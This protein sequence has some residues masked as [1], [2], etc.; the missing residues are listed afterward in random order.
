VRRVSPSLVGFLVA[1]AACVMSVPM[2][3]AQMRLC[4][5]NKLFGSDIQTARHRSINAAAGH[6]I[7]WKTFNACT[8][9]GNAFTWVEIRPE[10]QPDGSMLH[11]NVHCERA[12]I[13]WQCEMYS[14]RTLTHTVT[15]GGVEHKVNVNLPAGFDA[16]AARNLIE[17]AIE[18]APALEPAQECSW[19][20][21]EVQSRLED[22]LK[23]LKTSFEFTQDDAW[24]F[25][26]QTAEGVDVDSNDNLLRFAPDAADPTRFY[27]RCWD[28][29][30]VVT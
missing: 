12:Y 14:Y 29:E 25:I 5:K 18:L 16:G 9:P 26:R 28:I 13:K 1:I 8:N 22:W 2:A 27:F 10:A 19:T 20:R 7:D 3:Q 4:A 30:I 21:G 17:H 11:A 24:L 15:A 23:D 6:E